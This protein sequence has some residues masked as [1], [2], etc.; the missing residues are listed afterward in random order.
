MLTLIAAAA[1]FSCS[2]LIAVDGDTI[3]CD[4]QTMRELGDG[5]PFVSGIDAPEIRNA[6]CE[7]ER[8][9]GEAAKQRLEELISEDGVRIEYSG[10]NDRWGRPLVWIRMVNGQTAGSILME[11]GHAERWLPGSSH[12]WCGV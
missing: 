5:A 6:K 8:R 2:E 11:E 10:E 1:V 4:G 3:R 9:L 7:R 12:D